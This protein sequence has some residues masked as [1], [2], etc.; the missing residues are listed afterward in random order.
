MR[1]SGGEPVSVFTYRLRRSSIALA[2]ESPSATLYEAADHID[3]LERKLA[4][5]DAAHVPTPDSHGE[6]VYCADDGFVWP[7]RTHRILHPEATP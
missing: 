2:R 4:A 7:C 5:L 1:L 3:T 6:S